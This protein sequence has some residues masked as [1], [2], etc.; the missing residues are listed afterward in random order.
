MAARCTSHLGETAKRESPSAYDAPVPRRSGGTLLGI[1]VV[2]ILLTIATFGM[3]RFWG[4]VRIR[5]FMLS[6]TS[7]EGAGGP[8]AYFDSPADAGA[9]E[10]ARTIEVLGAILEEAALAELAR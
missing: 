8:R 6:Q 2:N 10:G 4:K 3:Y 7:F 9:D 5:R 1:Y